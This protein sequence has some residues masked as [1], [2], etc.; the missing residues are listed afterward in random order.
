MSIHEVFMGTHRFSFNSKLY[1]AVLEH[2][3]TNLNS[4]YSLYG[5]T[6]MQYIY[7]TPPPN[8]GAQW[9]ES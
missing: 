4:I 5:T 2:I 8:S 1:N 6:A 3:E 7:S 9:Q